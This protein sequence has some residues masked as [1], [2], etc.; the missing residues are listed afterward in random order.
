MKQKVNKSIAIILIALL[1]ASIMSTSTYAT[2]YQKMEITMFNVGAGD[3]FYIEM[4]NGDDILID[5]GESYYGSNI[6]KQLNKKEK[7]MTLEAVISTHPDSDHSGGLQEVFKKMQVKKFYYPK[8]ASYKSKTA[9][10][11]LN[12]VKLEKGCKIYGATPGTK[13]NGGNN[14]YIKF[15]HS[16]IDYDTTNK[17]SVMCYVKYNN[18]DVLLTGDVECGAEYKNISKINMDIV[19]A[20]HH[21]SKSSSSTEF[22]KKFDPENVLISTDGKSY[23]HPHKETLE[24]YAKYD[25]NIKVYQTNKKGNVSIKSNGKTWTYSCKGDTINLTPKKPVKSDTTIVY[26]TKTGKKYHK[27][28]TCSGL[29]NAKAIYETPLKDA[30][31][32]GLTACSICWLN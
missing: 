25:K 17:D 23:G 4:P 15:I 24:R 14:S 32:N 11:L 9:K 10:K 12:L 26:T 22:I 30:K 1:F 6:V 28:K 2:T 19:Q 27:I 13:I 20:P 16:K 31:N 21:G 29:S 18:L 3:C 5:S 8:D 7:G